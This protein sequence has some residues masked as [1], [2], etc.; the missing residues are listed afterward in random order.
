MSSKVLVRGCLKEIFNEFKNRPISTIFIVISFITIIEIPNCFDSQIINIFKNLIITFN[1]II[2]SIILFKISI[3]EF[4]KHQKS[5]LGYIVIYIVFMWLNIMKVDGIIFQIYYYKHVNILLF[6]RAI[7]YVAFICLGVH[8]VWKSRKLFK[9]QFMIY[10]IISIIMVIIGFAGFYQALYSMYFC[11][12]LEPLSINQ[13]MSYEQVLLSK[14]FIYYSIDCFFN[15]DISNVD[16]NYIDISESSKILQNPNKSNINIDS[17]MY[18]VDITKIAS[19]VEL[20]IFIVYFSII[21][22]GS[23]DYSEEKLEN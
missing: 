1:L 14:D 3:Q 18:V 11:F 2:T 9:N 16:I 22:L 4:N 8:I 13:G 12:D 19:L 21:I 15:I 10:L 6:L 5:S 23:N 17:A 7:T 20:I